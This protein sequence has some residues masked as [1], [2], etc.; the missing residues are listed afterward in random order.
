MVGSEKMS[1]RVN[2]IA[3]LRDLIDPVVYIDVTNDQCLRI[4][5]QTL[6]ENIEAGAPSTLID[7]M[8]NEI[9]DGVNGI[10]EL[11][12]QYKQKEKTKE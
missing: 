1:I 12:L 9:V 8:Y 5:K 2:L 7:D 6:K 10:G 11:Y 4:L 3:T